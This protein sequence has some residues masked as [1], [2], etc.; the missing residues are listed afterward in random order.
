MHRDMFKIQDGVAIVE[1]LNFKNSPP[2]RCFENMC[3]QDE[4]IKVNMQINRILYH[5][6]T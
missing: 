5:M 6:Y 4:K 1:K 2:W 3:M